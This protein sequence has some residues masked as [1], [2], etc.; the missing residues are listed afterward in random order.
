M[1]QRRREWTQSLL[2]AL[3]MI[4]NYV[5]TIFR[6]TKLGIDF[7]IGGGNVLFILDGHAIY[8]NGAIEE[9]VHYSIDVWAT[10]NSCWER[11]L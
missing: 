3:Y 11:I 6:K 8:D 5:G 9:I 7:G 2:E 1:V 4:N 10:N